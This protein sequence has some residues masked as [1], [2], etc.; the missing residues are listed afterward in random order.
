MLQGLEVIFSNRT[1]MLESLKKS[2]YASYFEEFVDQYGHYFEEMVAYVEMAAEPDKAAIEIGKLIVQAAKSAGVNKKG[3]IDAKNR[4]EL[5]MFMI[6]YVFP[7]MLK[8]GGEGR[9]LADGVLKVW[10]KEMKNRDMSYTDY[11]TLYY[12]FKEK[13]FGLF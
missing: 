3:K 10:R 1:K 11:E 6:Y 8:Q 7:T 5:H 13:I 4:S 9:T 2:S 12:G